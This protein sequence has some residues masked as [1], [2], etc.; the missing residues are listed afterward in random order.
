MLDGQPAAR[1]G[2]KR[3]DVIVELNGAPVADM[4][5]FRLQVA[6]M[7]VGSRINLVV[8]RDG[9]RLPVTLTLA[10]RTD[11]AVARS[12][13][14]GGDE[15][16][17]APGGLR[18]RDLTPEEKDRCLRAVGGDRDRG[19]RTAAPRRSRGCSRAT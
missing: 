10:E 16:A 9:R 6:D 8:L 2:L 19:R 4:Q 15:P 3:N 11:A 13:P 17:P 7:P 18:V 12:R 5:K 1:A 14:S